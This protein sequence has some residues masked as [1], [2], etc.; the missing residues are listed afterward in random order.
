MVMCDVDFHANLLFSDGANLFGCYFQKKT[1]EAGL[2][3][4]LLDK[5][6]ELLYP[7]WP[8]FVDKQNQFSS[9]ECGH[10]RL[11]GD[12]LKLSVHFEVT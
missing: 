5:P 2:N 10:L 7:I 11:W 12:Y 1:P 6:Q 9:F 8:P 3:P 4:N